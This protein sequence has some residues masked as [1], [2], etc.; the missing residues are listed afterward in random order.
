MQIAKQKDLGH[1]EFIEFKSGNLEMNGDPQPLPF[2][3]NLTFVKRIHKFKNSEEETY[4]FVVTNYGTYLYYDDLENLEVFVKSLPFP[5]PYN[6]QEHFIEEKVKRIESEISIMK[7][8]IQT[9]LVRL[10]EMNF[11]GE[12]VNE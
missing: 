7:D 9:I 2:K 3:I 5:L 11:V 1:D 10:N 8:H 6:Q 4:L 12:L